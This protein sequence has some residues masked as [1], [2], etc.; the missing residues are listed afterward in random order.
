MVSRSSALNILGMYR[1]LS[2]P[3]P[4]SPVIEPP[5][6]M[7]R[8]RISPDTTL[9]AASAPGLASSNSTSG[10]RLPSPAWK[11]FATLIPEDADSSA[12]A[13]STSGSA[14]RG[15]TPSC[16]MYAG[17]IRPTAANADL[18][19]VQIA[20]RSAASSAARIS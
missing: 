4:C 5:C 1:D 19:P 2:T 12:I 8:S 20:A 9:A 14:V 13:S 3:T 10:C 11:T 15:T 16:T 7:H 17:L 18:R 6:E